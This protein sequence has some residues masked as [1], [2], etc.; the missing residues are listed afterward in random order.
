MAFLGPQHDKDLKRCYTTVNDNDIYL[1]KPQAIA[2]FTESLAD[3]TPLQRL[4][5][6]V[7]DLALLKEVAA[8][9]AKGRRL[10]V[11][12]THID[13]R[14]L[15]VWD[16]GAIASRGDA[17][18]LELFRHILLAS[19]SIP[20][21]FPPVPF[22]VEVNGKLY[23]ELHVDGGV[24]ASMFY[25]PPHF[26]KEDAAKAGDSPLS[27]SNLYIIVAGKLYADPALVPL[28]FTRIAT[29]S[30]SSLIFSQTR[31]D[32]YQLYTLGLV[33]GMNFR[34]TAIPADFAVTG[35]STD[36]NRKEM[37]KLFEEGRRIAVLGQAWRST[38]PGTERD[39]QVVSRTG[40]KFTIV[41]PPSE[42]PVQQ[43]G[44]VTPAP[45]PLVKPNGQP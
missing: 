1:L 3:S 44:H 6:S 35:D 32:L 43:A 2:I 23:E 18:S 45:P 26:S 38:P 28:R 20:G 22:K 36:F 10:Y 40:T 42:N 25:R 27:G 14:R 7:V 8:E 24:S 17:E 13:S 39:E 9:Y 19:A 34:F 12:T 5:A 4:I 11:G 41:S 30:I 16:M 15:V 21:F 33:N 29:D 31:G 37:G